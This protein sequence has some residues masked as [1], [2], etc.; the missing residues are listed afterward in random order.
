MFAAPEK[1]LT[2]GQALYTQTDITTRCRFSKSHLYN[3]I[4]RGH[5]P[6]AALRCGPRFTRWKVSDV[7]EWLSDPQ[8]W[9]NAHAPE[10]QVVSA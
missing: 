2:Q 4:E 9:I 5:F 7:Q 3:L 8:G 6:P 10:A 1:S